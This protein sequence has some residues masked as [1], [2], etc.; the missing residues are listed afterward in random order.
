MTP[1]ARRESSAGSA[2]KGAGRFPQ[3]AIRSVFREIISA[4][5]SLEQPV[6]VSFLGPEG[7]FAHMAAR[8][9]FGLAAHYREATTI[10]GVF[11]A[12]R[13]G[14]AAYGVVPIENSTEGSVTRSADAL[15]EGDLLVR[16]ELVLDVAHVL[17]ARAGLGLSSIDRVY[18]H[19]QA[20]AQCRVWLAK[21]VP[22][23]QLVQTASTAA[24]AREA[25]ADER[26]AAIGSRLAA[27]IYGLEALR[28]GLHDR[29]ENATRFFVL[30]K[31][32]APR[33]G[34][35][36]TTIA[37]SVK[38]GRGALRNVL[39]C[40]RRRRDQPHPDRVASKPA[41]AV[42][43]RVPRRPRRAPRGRGGRARAHRA[44][45]DDAR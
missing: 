3:G 15:I 14:D 13:T 25:L 20:L 36:R 5:L 10:E 44:G 22:G 16:Q 34:Q 21:N 7:T 37:F 9:L 4:C 23:A 38:D 40:L 30:A 29:P 43:L 41:E 27:E 42:G 1:S 39:S 31:K 35:D 26:G 2:T 32:D 28:E 45:R 11:D 24:A 19:P 18:S 33:T 6:A 8:H 12:V 17:L